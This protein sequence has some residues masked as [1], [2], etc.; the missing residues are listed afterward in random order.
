MQN[1]LLTTMEK[2][3]QINEKGKQKR[4]DSA[5]KLLQMEQE[6]KQKLLA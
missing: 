5:A 4:K 3:A 2:C 1:E 6:L